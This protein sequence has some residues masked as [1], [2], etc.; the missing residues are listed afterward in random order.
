MKGFVFVSSQ[1][2][3]TE[4]ELKEWVDLGIE[5]CRTLPAKKSK[6]RKS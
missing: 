3:A 5:F 6:V 2:V 1:G 4:S